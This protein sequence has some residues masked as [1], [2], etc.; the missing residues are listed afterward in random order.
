MCGE[1]VGGV[2]RRRVG[3]TGAAW[4]RERLRSSSTGEVGSR[5]GGG[6]VES[7]GAAAAWSGEQAARERRRRDSA[8]V[9]AAERCTG[10]GAGAAVSRGG[11]N[12]RVRLT[13][14]TRGRVK[15][16][17]NKRARQP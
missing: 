9:A 11:R 6:A 10:A 15:R 14:G 17:Q 12:K 5:A 7:S 3:G 16:K 2:E 1:A 4:A 13:R 8:G